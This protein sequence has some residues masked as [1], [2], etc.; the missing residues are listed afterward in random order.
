MDTAIEDVKIFC[1]DGILTDYCTAKDG[2]EGKKPQKL[3]L[4]IPVKKN[5]KAAEEKK[6]KT[7]KEFLSAYLK[8]G[9]TKCSLCGKE[10][11]WKASLKRHVLTHS[12]IKEFECPKCPRA[13]VD[14]DRLKQHMQ[15]HFQEKHKCKICG[16]FF[17]NRAYLRTHQKRHTDHMKYKCYMCGQR[18]VNYE[19]IK[20]HIIYM[21][22]RKK[23]SKQPNITCDKCGETVPRTEYKR[24]NN[25]HNIKIQPR[26]CF[27][28]G[29][30]LSSY[31]SLK[32][33]SHTYHNGLP[34]DT[35]LDPIVCPACKKS[36][37]SL[38]ILKDHYDENHALKNFECDACGSGFDIKEEFREHIH[39][40]HVDVGVHPC[41]DCG[42]LFDSRGNMLRHRAK[43]HI[44][45]S[46]VC[47]LCTKRKAFS[48]E[49]YFSRHVETV[50]KP[51]E[52]KDKAEKKGKKVKK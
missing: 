21:H 47:Y 12:N 30:T 37:E 31:A 10:Y 45:Y 7:T 9:D 36:F 17:K 20:L 29:K 28:C 5:K 19:T 52:T 44:D 3:T 51:F 23:F 40:N 48:T 18:F 49:F 32:R 50:H 15:V 24:H 39:I 4:R 35:K 33:H 13:F 41:F 42:K 1:V 34:V 26:D 22:Y 38:E 46:Y 25:T 6:F 14:N 16:H 11:K 43:A 2:D 8:P 27:Y